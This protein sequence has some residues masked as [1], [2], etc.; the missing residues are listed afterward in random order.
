[1]TDTP[2]S[3]HQERAGFNESTFRT[4]NEGINAGRGLRATGDRVGFLCE[5]ARLGCNAVIELTV[6]E[7]EELRRHARRFV[8]V[9]GHEFP[10]AERV[11]ERHDAHHVVQK[12]GDAAEVADATDLRA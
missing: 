8:V 9:P 3:S 4:V 2:S 6:G 7:Y 1:M 12:V 10:G 11:V 5:C